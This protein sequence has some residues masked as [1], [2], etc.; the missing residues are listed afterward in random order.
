[1]TKLTFLKCLLLLIL[2]FCISACGFQLRSANN[3]PPELRVLYLDIN[4]NYS[5]FNIKLE[6]MLR[7]LNIKLT[8][9]PEEAPITLQ[10]IQNQIH[11]NTP[12]IS[13]GNSAITY[14]YTMTFTFTLLNKAGKALI[15]PQVL[16][17]SER[18]LMNVNQIYSNS[19]DTAIKQQLQRE[20]LMKIYNILSSGEV[21]KLLLQTSSLHNH[22]PNKP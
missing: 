1:M 9:T 14:T 5:P 11:H 12:D 19:A 18:L 2:S 16:H 22:H 15:R 17:T 8:T 13:T 6:N 10:I 20:M 21:K 7:S 4:N 3:M